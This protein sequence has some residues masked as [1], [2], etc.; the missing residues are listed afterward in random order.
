MASHVNNTHNSSATLQITNNFSYDA[1]ITIHHRYD[2]SNDEYYEW[3]DV[4]PGT[5]T[6]DDMTV[7]FNTGWLHANGHDYWRAE[8]KIKNGPAKGTYICDEGACTLHTGDVGAV[9]TFSVSD[10]GFMCAA[11]SN[12]CSE[13]WSTRPTGN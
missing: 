2:T 9:L 7:T 3:T 6:D 13:T 1:D 5:T 10:R 12:H 8:V 11:S 4:M